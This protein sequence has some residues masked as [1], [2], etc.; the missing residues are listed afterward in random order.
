MVAKGGIEPT[1]HGF[2]VRHQKGTRSDPR[3]EPG[4]S[5]QYF[6][7]VAKYV[8]GFVQENVLGIFPRFF[9]RKFIDEIAFTSLQAIV[10]QRTAL[11]RREFPANHVIVGALAEVPR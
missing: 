11:P 7:L 2:L 10:P 8:D 6:H 1:A 9:R 5:L 3:R 4:A